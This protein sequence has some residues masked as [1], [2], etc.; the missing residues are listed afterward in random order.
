MPREKV[1]AAITR[2]LETTLMRVGNEEYAKT[3]KSYGLTTLRNRHVKLEGT[4]R[5]YFDFRG[6]H[7]TEHH[8]DLRDRRLASIVRRCQELPGQELFQYL[9]DNGTPHVVSS[10]D[11]NEYLRAI[12]GAEIT[13]KDF[14]TWAATNLAALALQE[15]E[16]FDSQTKAKSNVVRAVEAVSKMLGNTPAIC[17]KCYIHPAVFDGYL[18][19]SL[20]QALKRRADAKLANPRAGLKAEEVAV[21]GFL[22]RQLAATE[23]VSLRQPRVRRQPPAELQQQPR[24]AIVVFEHGRRN[25][26]SKAARP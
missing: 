15:L 26:D 8:I 1:L 4:S 14:R 23:R 22:S 16:S 17:R 5:I 25:R 2:L 7:G 24:T 10:D 18:D 9:D 6:K 11:V 13:A 3:N 19:G 21:M 20:L 12:A